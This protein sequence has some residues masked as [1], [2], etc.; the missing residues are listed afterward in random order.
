[1]PGL[2]SIFIQMLPVDKEAIARTKAPW[3]E[4]GP[5]LVYEWAVVVRVGWRVGRQQKRKVRR[6]GQELS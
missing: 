6:P 4:A 3:L 5:D 2:Q 1:M